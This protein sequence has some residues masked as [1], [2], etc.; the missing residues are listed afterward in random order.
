MNGKEKVKYNN[1][2]YG[3]IEEN[4]QCSADVVQAD[5]P[6]G[7]REVSAGITVRK[8]KYHRSKRQ[9]FPVGDGGY[10]MKKKTI[11]VLC[12]VLAVVLAGAGILWFLFGSKA[13]GEDESVVYVNTIAQLTGVTGGNGLQN[14]FAGVIE[15][16]TTWK[17]E[18]NTEK[19]VKE[20]YV[21]AGQEVQKGTPLFSYDTDQIQEK[22]EQ[23]RLDLERAQNERSSMSDSIAQLQKEKKSAPKDQQAA[24]TL[25]IQQAELDLKK[26]EYDIKSKQS[27]IEGLENDILNAT[28]VSEIAGV[29][30][31]VNKEDSNGGGNYYGSQDNAFITVLETGT[32]QV[33]GTINEQNMG[34]ISQGMRVIVHSRADSE[35]TW[36]GSVTKIDTENAQSSGNSYGMMSD[37]SG[38]TQSSNY[39]F[40]VELDNGEGLMLGQHVYIEP[41][42]GQADEPKKGLWLP[43]Y[44][45]NDKDSSPYVWADNGKEKL[46]KRSVK[47]GAYDE[48]TM[49]YEIKDG[50]TAKDAITFPEE[51]LE[52]G[53]TTV[54]SEDGRM[55]QSNPQSDSTEEIPMNGTEIAPEEASDDAADTVT[56]DEATVDDGATEETTEEGGGETG[57][58]P[59]AREAQGSEVA[60]P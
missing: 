60:V 5:K 21:E 29:V 36:G 2:E 48:S 32:F 55:G 26:K 8:M 23:S 27:E 43:E 4:D 56:Q 41:D 28:V 11:A 52:E 42:N 10:E 17:V 39:P 20:I 18:K 6:N 22:L 15:S 24:L 37:S 13:K 51:G 49:E 25:E 46:E 30:K 35:K 1:P 44:Y 40:Y 16:K 57:T 14:R 58:V 38:K 54:I 53:M 12:A 47:L 7:K 33:K 3:R 31:S 34:T 9:I 19:T 50:L 45:I 59:M